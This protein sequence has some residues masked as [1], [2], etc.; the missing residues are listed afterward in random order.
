LGRS[1]CL[2]SLTRSRP[3]AISLA[4]SLGSGSRVADGIMKWGFEH[5]VADG[6]LWSRLHGRITSEEQDFYRDPAEYVA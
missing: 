3:A 2:V 5:D 4:N 6:I 1:S